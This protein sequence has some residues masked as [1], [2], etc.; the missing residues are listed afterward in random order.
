MTG[1]IVPVLQRHVELRARDALKNK[2]TAS[3]LSELLQHRG[4]AESTA[5]FPAQIAPG[6]YET[7]RQRART[8]A[9][10]V[11]ESGAAFDEVLTLGAS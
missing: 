7:A 4:T 1:E 10:L 9:G 3:R 11:R 6:C 8:A 5:V 2:Q